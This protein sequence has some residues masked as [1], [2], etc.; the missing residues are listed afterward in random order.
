MRLTLCEIS[1]VFKAFEECIPVDGDSRVLLLPWD[2]NDPGMVN[3]NCAQKVSSLVFGFDFHIGFSKRPPTLVP[4][5]CVI[6]SHV[7]VHR[8]SLV[9][10]VTSN[11]NTASERTS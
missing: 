2:S 3:E 7:S 9:M 8:T 6:L 5:A 11:L 4:K 1:Q 10:E